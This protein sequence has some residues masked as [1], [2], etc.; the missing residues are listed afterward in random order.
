M[1]FG[2]A[3]RG[4]NIRES[5]KV[6]KLKISYLSSTYFCNSFL[7][8]TT[9]ATISRKQEAT[10]SL[11]SNLIL[12]FTDN[13]LRGPYVGV[14]FVISIVID[15][16]RGHCYEIFPPQKKKGKIEDEFWVAGKSKKRSLGFFRHNLP[17]LGSFHP[18]FVCKSSFR[19]VSMIKIVILD[20]SK[21]ISLILKNSK[22]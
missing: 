18:Y 15:S 7:M 14:V 11:P 8:R 19:V 10:A 17:P 3:T 4:L 12:G 20:Q 16:D 1:G 22:I 2:C 21:P 6:L 9:F 5:S 13:L